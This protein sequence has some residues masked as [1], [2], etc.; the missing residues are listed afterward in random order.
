MSK[1]KV[2]DYDP[3]TGFGNFAEIMNTNNA[4]DMAQNKLNTGMAPVTAP[5]ANPAAPVTGAPMKLETPTPT[6]VVGDA[7]TVGGDV[8]PTATETATETGVTARPITSTP[9]TSGPKQEESD[10]YAAQGLDPDKDYE[11]AR[12]ALEYDYETSMATYGQRAEQLY[13]MGL[14]NSGVSDIYQLGAFNAY[15]KSQNDLAYRRI[16]AKKKNKQDYL[17][18]ESK[19]QE[20]VKTDTANAYNFGLDLFAYDENDKSNAEYVR[21]QL[22]DRGYD[23]AIVDNV[24]NSLSRVDKDTL[25][26]MKA[27]AQAE[28]EA[29]EKAN[30]R[31]E[32]T[33][34][35]KT[36]AYNSFNGENI[37]EV[38]TLLAAQEGVDSEMLAEIKAY[39]TGL[40]PE[41]LA[42]STAYKNKQN[43]IAQEQAAEKET[44]D[45]QVREATALAEQLWSGA[46]DSTTGKGY[47]GSVEKELKKRGYSD[48]VIAA[49]TQWIR[50]AGNAEANKVVDTTVTNIYDTLVSSGRLDNYKGTKVERDDLIASLQAAG[51]ATWTINR[52]MARIDKRLGATQ[53]VEEQ[54]IDALASTLM[55]QYDDK[56]NLIF[57]YDGSETSKLEIKNMLTRRGQADLYDSVIAS[58]DAK[59]AEGKSTNLNDVISEVENL[60][61]TELSFGNVDSALKMA[62]DQYGRG[63]EEYEKVKSAMSTRVENAFAEAFDNID[64]SL[65]DAYEL[66]GKTA[67]EWSNMDDGERILALL[68]STKDYVSSH[69]M[70]KEAKD[71]LF[72]EW[73]MKEIEQTPT[74]SYLDMQDHLRDLMKQIEIFDSSGH[75]ESN[76]YY[77]KVVQEIKNKGLVYADLEA[78]GINGWSEIVD[79]LAEALRKTIAGS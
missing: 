66:A 37:G 54:D 79:I 40:T 33:S 44:F 34:R 32:L 31:A 8:V 61:I 1:K 71:A 64:D 10:W 74:T 43:A 12:A 59:L 58:M 47:A 53:K 72:N 21:Q 22:I 78:D 18:Y 30:K 57:N 11:E 38:E 62:L 17:A 51:Y 50:D 63:T 23:A 41:Q 24:I 14:S 4:I 67:E 77:Y 35:L 45:A 6:P 9:I 65:E 29:T 27:R 25:P 52:V 73:I 16:E 7:A 3:K 26:T 69:A 75:I 49:A 56:G 70:S 5:V 19:Y 15:L 20:G 60:D 36:I 42:N 13:Q 39:L 68:E 28:A 2:L 76:D 46:I 48:E 55:T